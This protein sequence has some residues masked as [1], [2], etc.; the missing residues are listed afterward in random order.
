METYDVAVVG[1]GPV[2]VA[3]CNLLARSGLR[4]A[5][6]DAF[7]GPYS[8]PRATH[9]D[10][11]ALRILQN[12][13]VSD[14]LEPTLGVYTRMRFVN[15]GGDLLIDWPRSIEEGWQ[16]WRDSNRF[17]QPALETVLRE[18][19]ARY[20]NLSLHL[21]QRIDALSQNDEG[22]TFVARS[23]T[24]EGRLIGAR[25]VVGCDGANSTVRTAV[26][27]E[28]ESL[29][30][31]EQWLVVDLIANP[32]APPLPEGTVQY[33]DPIRPI[34]YIEAVGSRRRWEVMLSPGEDPARFAEPANVW[35]LISRW[36]TPDNAVIER[37]VVY[38]FRSVVAPTWRRGRFLLAGDA[39][40]QTPPFLGQGLCAGLRDVANLAWKLAWVAK[41]EASEDLL[42]TYQMEMEPHV[43]AYIAEANRIGAIIQE[44][45]PVR[46]RQ[47]D[48]T[49]RATPQ[50][51]QSARPRLGAGLGGD[52]AEPAGTLS[53]QPRL[54][55]G[56]RLDDIAPYGFILLATPGFTADT[57]AKARALWRRA[58]VTVLEGEAT[59][60]L[61]S[62]GTRAVLIRPDR[63]ILG[64]ADD[65]AQLEA[66]TT[67]L[68]LLAEDALC[69]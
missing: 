25:Y 23:G 18:A 29:G 27:G 58:G 9:L 36:L 35:S 40:H 26:G 47:R 24:G 12:L 14:S 22:A 51:L 30:R 17:H 5:G 39:A 67:R 48:D 65:P 19:A 49:L 44:R 68:P 13:G 28:L 32:G 53:A 4:V 54:A 59:L 37:A 43:R 3:L 38:T 60:W 20:P 45:D 41:G 6:F 69:A 61:D 62:L 8:L 57:S 64:T 66:V 10:G 1:L 63:Y 21:G 56:R 55:D 16:A 33:C 46:A 50:V 2:G 7:E 11:Q 15:A 34:T 31:P 42:D 52:A